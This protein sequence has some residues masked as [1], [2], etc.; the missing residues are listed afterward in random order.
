MRRKASWSYQPRHRALMEQARVAHFHH[1]FGLGGESGLTYQSCRFCGLACF[2]NEDEEHGA[3]GIAQRT[4]ERCRGLWKYAVRH[5]LC[6]S[7]RKSVLLG[8][9]PGKPAPALLSGPKTL[10][11]VP[12]VCDTAPGQPPAPAGE[13]GD[14]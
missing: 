4:G 9:A 5:Y 14:A 12:G 1:S 2:M 8:L 6:S 3:C 13:R 7:C 11:G 10:A